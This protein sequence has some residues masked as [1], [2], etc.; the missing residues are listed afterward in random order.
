MTQDVFISYSSCDEN[1]ARAIKQRLEDAGVSC[2]FAP[3]DIHPSQ[4]YQRS[5]VEALDECFVVLLVLSKGSNASAEV[6][7][8]IAHADIRGQQIV[9]ASIEG[10]KPSEALRP[11]LVGCERVS[12]SDIGAIVAAARR[13]KAR[14]VIAEHTKVGA[15]L[16]SFIP[17]AGL[18]FVGMR[19]SGLLLLALGASILVWS[20]FLEL[21]TPLDRSLSCVFHSLIFCSVVSTTHAVLGAITGSK[22]RNYRWLPYFAS[23]FAP[24]SGINYA[25]RRKCGWVF[26]WICAILFSLMMCSG[27]S[28]TFNGCCADATLYWIVWLLGIAESGF[29]D[30]HGK[31]RNPYFYTFIALFVFALVYF[32][33][34]KTI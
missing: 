10:E 6:L 12:G 13:A 5:L 32:N 30:E 14:S 34:P 16:L 2:W 18:L 4:N 19:R 33:L 7:S 1:A 11:L 27:M 15:I 31:H 24:A 8:E 21:G 9:V 20:Y 26:F 23:V 3:H 25:G 17:G 29:A 22:N 28:L